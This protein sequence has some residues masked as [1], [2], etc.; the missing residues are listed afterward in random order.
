MKSA[1]LSLDYLQA[2]LAPWVNDLYDQNTITAIELGVFGSP[3]YVL[4]GEIFWGQDR[5]DF[6]RE[7]LETL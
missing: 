5:L 1:D 7:R 6:L 2:S 3:S 4:N